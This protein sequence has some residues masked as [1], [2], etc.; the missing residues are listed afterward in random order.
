MLCWMQQMSHVLPAGNMTTTLRAQTMPQSRL[1]YPTEH[2][3]HAKNVTPFTGLNYPPKN[4][5]SNGSSAQLRSAHCCVAK[6]HWPRPE[7]RK[8]TNTHTYCLGSPTRIT[9][10]SAHTVSLLAAKCENCI[11]IWTQ[12]KKDWKKKTKTKTAPTLRQWWR[13]WQ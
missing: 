13:Q 4:R 12:T 9:Q 8:L 6:A 7:P 2:S 10:K 1:R 5:V 3:K 11:C